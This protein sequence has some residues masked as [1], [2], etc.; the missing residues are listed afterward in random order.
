MVAD[1]GGHGGRRRGVAGVVGV[2]GGGG[3]VGGPAGGLALNARGGGRHEAQ[4]RW[5]R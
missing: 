1:S 3:R 2:G 5:K 4:A